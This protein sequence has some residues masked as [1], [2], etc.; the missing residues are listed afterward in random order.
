MYILENSK[1][2]NETMSLKNKL[3]LLILFTV[4]SLSLL[5]YISLKTTILPSLDQQKTVYID[6]LI[7]KLQLSLSIENKYLAMLADDWADWERMLNYVR[8]PDKAFEEEAFSDDYFLSDT[9]HFILV[10]R[11]DQTV[12]F[13]RCYSEAWGNVTYQQL[14]IADKLKPLHG[15]V[16]N[17]EDGVAD[18]V[19]TGRGPLMVAIYPIKEYGIEN[20][21]SGVL[22]LGRFIDKHLVKKISSYLQENVEVVTV[23]EKPQFQDYLNQMQKTDLYHKEINNK[24]T[25]LYLARDISGE[26]S[27]ILKIKSDNQI[28]ATVNRH[29]VIFMIFIVLSII[30]PGLIF[31]LA[32]DKYIVKRMLKISNAMEK[33]ES[34]EDLSLRVE[35]DEG[36]KGDEISSLIANINEMLNKLEIERNKRE[37][38]QKMLLTTEKLV[39]LGRLSSSI[40]HEINNPILAIGN[41][42]Q[43]IKKISRGRSTP[44]KE[45]MHI[46]ESE[47]KRIR[48]ITS[49]LLNLHRL[50][51]IEFVP[52]NLKEV[53]LESVEVLKWGNKLESTQLTTKLKENCVVYGSPGK[54]KQV[55]INFILNA[56]EA[57]KNRKGRVRIEISSP[58]DGRFHEVHFW[59][60][61]RGI[62]PGIRDKLFVP[63]VSTKE[64]SGLGLGLYIAKSIIKN[65]SGEII[66][67]DSYC[68]GAHF[69]IKLPLAPGGNK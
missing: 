58:G 25:I 9:L 40:A 20:P 16:T 14:E 36:P 46:L 51:K 11:Q 29:T 1:D 13:Y 33:I 49:N 61:G 66:F 28:F 23:N 27:F 60:N 56:V 62:S 22:I 39:S 31:Y 24:M 50:D 68:Q 65:H 48:S 18:I 53:L 42:V 17:R 2:Y 30:V 43:V 3:Y 63:F 34:L 52:L 67:D 7:K 59:D 8:K 10:S 47:I 26:R 4:S 69:I 57:T 6:K 19:N 55:F 37:E 41:C 21:L 54:L 12:L 32:I 5:L 64:E 35:G 15:R 45:A 38:M 44:Y